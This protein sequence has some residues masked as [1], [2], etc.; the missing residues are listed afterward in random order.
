MQV[1]DHLSAL[2]KLIDPPPP[3]S[4]PKPPPRVSIGAVI[5]GID[6]HK[7]MRIIGRG[8]DVMVATP[9]RLWD[10]MSEVRDTKRGD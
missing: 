2:A 10:I 8:M 3:P 9:G 4:G 5:G 1:A 7:Q 6:S